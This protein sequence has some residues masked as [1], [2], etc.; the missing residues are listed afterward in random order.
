MRYSELGML[1]YAPFR[2]NI[3]IQM[4]YMKENFVRF[5]AGGRFMIIAPFDEGWMNKHQHPAV[6]LSCHLPVRAIFI[7]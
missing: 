6:L 4:Q 3:C 1:S 5:V 7:K 2:S